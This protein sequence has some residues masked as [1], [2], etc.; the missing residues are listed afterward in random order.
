[1]LTINKEKCTGCRV[2]LNVCPQN[3]LLMQNSKATVNDYK[4]CMECGA[5]QNNCSFNAI[6]VTKGTGCL[7]AIVKEDILKIAEKGTGC[8]C[9]AGSDKGC[10]QNEE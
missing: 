2:C 5:C 6:T 8:G 10:C 1:M 4:A 3:V 9:G 7:W